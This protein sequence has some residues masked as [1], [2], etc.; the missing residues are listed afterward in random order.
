MAKMS[1]MRE[2]GRNWVNFQICHIPNAEASKYL[3]SNYDGAPSTTKYGFLVRLDAQI[4]ALCTQCAKGAPPHPSRPLFMFGRRK[5]EVALNQT[6]SNSRIQESPL[7]LLLLQLLHICD[8]LKLTFVPK[9]DHCWRCE[10]QRLP[11]QLHTVRLDHTIDL[12]VGALAQ[13]LRP[14][15]TPCR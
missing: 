4:V 14:L 6:Q 3:L 7:R 10:L 9:G 12:N 1:E 8:S 2:S 13:G 15:H 5:T 11:I